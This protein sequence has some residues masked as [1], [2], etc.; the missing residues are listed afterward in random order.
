MNTPFSA[1]LDYVEVCVVFMYSPS[2]TAHRQCYPD[3]EVVHTLNIARC[4]QVVLSF[5]ISTSS[6]FALSV[7][8]F[9]DTNRMYVSRLPLTVYR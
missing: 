1:V 9:H 4:M 5:G 8:W 7:N 6:I 3:C 2:V